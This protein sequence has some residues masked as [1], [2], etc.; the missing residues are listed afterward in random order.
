MRHRQ[1]SKAQGG[2]GA[3]DLHNFKIVQCDHM[4]QLYCCNAAMR[5]AQCSNF[6]HMRAGSAYEQTLLQSFPS[7][8]DNIRTQKLV[9][10]T[11]EESERRSEIRFV[12]RLNPAS[13][14]IRQLI[15]LRF[16]ATDEDGKT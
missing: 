12:Q 8:K 14:A 9:D 4:I 2:G 16:G 1:M 15:E 5:H 13:K 10:L 11:E 3:F 7:Q 6:E